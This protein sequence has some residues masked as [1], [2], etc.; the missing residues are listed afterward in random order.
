MVPLVDSGSLTD[1]AEEELLARFLL[2]QVED[3][4]Q[5]GLRVAFESDLPPSELA[6]FIERF[7]SELF[8]I[9]YDIGNSASLGFDPIEEFAAY[10]S[11]IINVHVKDRH[12]GGTTVALGEGDAEFEVVFAGLSDLGYSGNLILQTARHPAGDHLLSLVRFRD[13]TVDWMIRHGL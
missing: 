4:D 3:L 1:K 8:G 12:F 9:N 10:G 5:F 7:P 13:M 2:S 6:A 11:R